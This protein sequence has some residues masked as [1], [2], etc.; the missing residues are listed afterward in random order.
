M[1]DVRIRLYRWG[2]LPRINLIDRK[3]EMWRM[4]CSMVTVIDFVVDVEVERHLTLL[5]IFLA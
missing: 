1:R 4:D 2:L 5:N 3:V